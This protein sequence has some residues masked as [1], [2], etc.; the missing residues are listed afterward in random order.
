MK[1]SFVTIG[2]GIKT[3]KNTRNFEEFEICAAQERIGKTK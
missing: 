3:K 2:R 1:F